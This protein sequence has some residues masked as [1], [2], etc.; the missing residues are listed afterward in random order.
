M[1]RIFF[2]TIILPL[3]VL[4]MQLRMKSLVLCLLMYHQQP[5]LDAAWHM[6]DVLRL[7]TPNIIS[8][9]LVIFFLSHLIRLT[10]KQPH[11]FLCF[12]FRFTPMPHALLTSL[13]SVQCMAMSYSSSFPFCHRHAVASCSTSLP[14]HGHAWCTLLPHATRYRNTLEQSSVDPV[15]ICT[16]TCSSI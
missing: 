10:Y 16:N 3:L 13:I 6:E 2:S 4:Q 15:Q 8:T 14:F 9:D 1:W 7:S 11:C 5:L 12:S